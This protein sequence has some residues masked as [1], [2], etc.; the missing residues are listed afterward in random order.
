MNYPKENELRD[1]EAWY[2]DL[3]SSQ[4]NNIDDITD[5]IDDFPQ[6]CQKWTVAELWS[7]IRDYLGG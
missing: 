4:Q 7:V 6:F 3:S 1:F 5:I 2:D